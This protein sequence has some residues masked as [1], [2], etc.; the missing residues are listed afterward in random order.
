M[1]YNTLEYIMIHC[2]TLS[3]PLR[4]LYSVLFHSYDLFRL[5]NCCTFLALSIESEMIENKWQ[6]PALVACSGGSKNVTYRQQT[7]LKRI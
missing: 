2:N 7:T 1:Y 6:G 5:H 3:H 4:Q